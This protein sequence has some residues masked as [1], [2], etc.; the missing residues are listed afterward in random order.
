M[1]KFDL[2]V[3]EAT[4]E[5]HEPPAGT[6]VVTRGFDGFGVTLDGRPLGWFDLHHFL[7]GDGPVRF[8]VDPPDEGDPLAMVVFRP[9]GRTAVVVNTERLRP[10]ASAADVAGVGADRSDEVYVEV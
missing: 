6:F 8:L 10:A 2:L 5:P 4:A 9:D 7:A 1:P 3:R